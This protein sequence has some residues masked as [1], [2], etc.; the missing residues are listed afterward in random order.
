MTNFQVLVAKRR[1]CLLD[2]AAPSEV[3]VVPDM[4]GLGKMTANW[5]GSAVIFPQTASFARDPAQYVAAVL[6]TGIGPGV[7]HAIRARRP[8]NDN[9]TRLSERLRL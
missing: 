7:I 3:P 9:N 8:E 2:R 1:I 4:W 5:G 6:L